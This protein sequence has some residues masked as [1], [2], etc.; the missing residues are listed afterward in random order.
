MLPQSLTKRIF[1]AFAALGV[2]ML[3]AVSASLF[4]VLRDAHRDQI[5][6]SLGYQIVAF[7]AS[8]VRNPASGQAAL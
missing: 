5:T 4:L 2:A 3:V 1:L 6:Q 7:E 8:L